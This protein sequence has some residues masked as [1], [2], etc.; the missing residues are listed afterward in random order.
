MGI[1]VREVSSSVLHRMSE[2][3]PP[4]K[5]LALIGRSPGAGLEELLGGPGAVWL[6]VGVIYP[7][8]VGMAI[9][10]AEVSGADGVIIDADFNA[11]AR[12]F[13][14][15]TSVRSD[16]YMPV[17]WERAQTVLDAAAAAGRPVIGI[18]HVGTEAPWDLDLTGRVLLV[19]GGEADGIP[20]DVLQRCIQVVRIPTAGF[21]PSYNVQA[22][23][24]AIAVERLRQSQG[25][26]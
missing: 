21:I 10:T 16:W 2:C 3:D 25:S 17:L 15:R 1:R 19:V 8:N 13:A 7:G 24:A 6:L 14:L 22:A 26:R 11:T 9:R 23:I 20:G 5:L 12:R 18:E 4:A